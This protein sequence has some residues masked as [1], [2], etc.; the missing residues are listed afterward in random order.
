[1]EGVVTLVSGYGT[2]S[3]Y[4]MY[5]TSTTFATYLEVPLPHQGVIPAY[6]E[7]II[8]SQTICGLSPTT[9]Y[10]KAMAVRD[11]GLPGNQII[12]GNIQSFIIKNITVLIES[13]EPVRVRTKTLRPLPP[14][15]YHD[16][17]SLSLSL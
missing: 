3:V 5:S 4:Y 11:E 15:S 16:V 8:P 2:L 17:S 9:Y 1:M 13:T 12:S 14:L 6:G 7:M 10:Y